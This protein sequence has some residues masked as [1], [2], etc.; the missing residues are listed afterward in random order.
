M[1][2]VRVF[3]LAKEMGIPA[4][5]LMTRLRKMG[6]SVKS[7]SSTVDRLVGAQ[8]TGTTLRVHE[9]AKELGVPTKELTSRLQAMGVEVKSH[10]SAVEPSVLARLTAP[11]TPLAVPEAPDAAPATAPAP[12]TR[13]AAA[14]PLPVPMPPVRTATEPSAPVADEPPERP[15]AAG[16]AAAPAVDLPRPISIE[17]LASR[18]E[19]LA[20]L[21][22]APVAVQEP[23]PDA[24]P[25]RRAPRVRAPGPLAR[26]RSATRSS[27]ERIESAPGGRLLLSLFCV[28]IVAA[29]LVSN[30][31][32]SYSG[33]L[34][35]RRTG[36]V[37][38]NAQLYQGWNMFA[39]D[40]PTFNI[41]LVAVVRYSD[42][43][44][45]TWSPP[46]YNRFTGG[47]RDFRWRRSDSISPQDSIYYNGLADWL[48]RKQHKEDGRNAT[49][50]IFYQATAPSPAPG[51]GAKSTWQLVR[52]LSV[53]PVLDT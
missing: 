22:P 48:A 21:A 15:A 43:T 42:G 16:P 23:P 27:Q 8:L 30:L 28:A 51:S 29:V 9:V 44:R 33:D 41:R 12:T 47:Y 5:D 26:A 4:A 52:V 38:V 3:E 18:A 7:H 34:A 50:V 36:R 20:R 40:P 1:S 25:E 32:S 2:K 31:P 24:Q 53:H 14:Q 11:E 46:V 10:M 19:R 37:L 39:P 13:E 35:K 6:V 45:S 17:E 49:E